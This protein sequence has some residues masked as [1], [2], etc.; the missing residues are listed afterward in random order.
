V[1]SDEGGSGDPSIEDLGEDS[2]RTAPRLHSPLVTRHSSLVTRADCLT[3]LRGL[4]DASVDVIATDPA[5]SGMNRHMMFGNGRI[6]G[7]YQS[8]TNG[9][10]F[11]EF[12][13]DEATYRD[14]L[15]Q[16]HRVLRP[17]G[18][19]YVMF[20]SFSLLTLGPLVREF[21]DVKN[22]I[23]WDKVRLGMGHYFRRRHEHVVFATKGN[24]KLTRRDLPDVW[25]FPRIYP[26]RYPTQKPV[27]L[28]EA[29]LVGSAKPGDAVCDPFVG[30][31]SAA[32][33]ALRR[34]CSFV[35]CDISEKAV[36]FSERRIAAFRE[37]GND[38][39]Q[40]NAARVESESYSWLDPPLSPGPFLPPGE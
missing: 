19:L 1:T 12:H 38:P 11:A 29:M 10:W 24:R 23:V 13:D 31:G 16:C 35:G 18:H 4:A 36:A 9:K 34:G 33:A 17:D 28:F 30:S 22:L 8:P 3:F 7:D 27:E 21:F 32:I 39:A 6:V 37:T 20:D 15:R 25:R 2:A 26:A 5:Y 40:P 14:F